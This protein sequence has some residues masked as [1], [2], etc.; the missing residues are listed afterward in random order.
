MSSGKISAQK[1]GVQVKKSALRS[2]VQVNQVL[3]VLELRLNKCSK[4]KSSGK[5]SALSSRVKVK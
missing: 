3:R 5:T 2:R 1:L 4:V